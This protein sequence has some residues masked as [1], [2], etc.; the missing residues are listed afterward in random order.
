MAL[1]GRVSPEVQVIHWA[2][3]SDYARHG[4]RGLLEVLL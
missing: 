2:Q 3:L 1:S 4:E